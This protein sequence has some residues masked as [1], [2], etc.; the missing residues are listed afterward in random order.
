MTAQS[1]MQTIKR[2]GVRAGVTRVHAHLFRHTFAVKWRRNKGD[3]FA[4]Q[5]VLGHEDLSVTRMYI[6]LAR[7]KTSKLQH[8]SVSPVDKL[9]VRAQVSKVGG[10]SFQQTT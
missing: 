1:L 5:A 3:V 10:S 9:G 7:S 8:R 6:Q 2:L 4:L